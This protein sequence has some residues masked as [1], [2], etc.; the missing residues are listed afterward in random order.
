MFLYSLFHSLVAQVTRLYDSD[1][2]P[3]SVGPA[4]KI[5]FF[6]AEIVGHSQKGR[7]AYQ[8]DALIGH[9]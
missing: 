2:Q 8:L 6:V 9:R 1:V 5:H 3:W 7:L 4:S